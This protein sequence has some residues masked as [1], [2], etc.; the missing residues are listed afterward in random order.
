MWEFKRMSTASKYQIQEC[1]IALYIES[2]EFIVLLKIVTIDS[3]GML[4]TSCEI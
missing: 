3:K 2:N 1:V 4:K